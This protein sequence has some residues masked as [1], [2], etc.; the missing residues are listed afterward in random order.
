MLLAAA[1]TIGYWV[2]YFTSGATR[3]R[4]DAEYLSFEDAFPLADGW[5]TLCFLLGARGMWRGDPSGVRWGLCGGSAMI[6]LGC[7]GLLY[8]LEHG[9]FGGPLS[10]ALLAEVVVLTYCF[11]FGPITLL[12]L[13]RRP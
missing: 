8:D 9:H 2:A 1:G 7:M 10:A 6:F 4:G 12:R 5:M 11:T 3:V 13:W